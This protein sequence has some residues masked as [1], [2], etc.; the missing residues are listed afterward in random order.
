[1]NIKILGIALLSLIYVACNNSNSHEGHNHDEESHEGHDHSTDVENHEEH[2]EIKFQY[3]SNPLLH[4][5]PL[6]APATQG[7]LKLS[8]K[9][10]QI[11][12]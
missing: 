9:N 4:E 5:N 1:M 3:S 7:T 10:N 6:D 2:E 11:Y 12:S 8:Q